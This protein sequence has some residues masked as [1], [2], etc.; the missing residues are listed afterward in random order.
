VKIVEKTNGS[1]TSTKQ[2]VWCPGDAQP[3]EERDA[4][5]NVTKRYYP[6]G[7]RIGST[8][9]Y[10]TRDHLGSIRELT[11]G[12]GAV[13]TRYDYDPYGRRTRLTGT[14]DA[15]FGFT[16]HY[17]HQPSGLHLALYRAY[18]ADLGR[19]ISRD[20]IGE[21]GGVNLYAYITNDPLNG[22]DPLGLDALSNFPFTFL[23][24]LDQYSQMRNPKQPPPMTDANGNKLNRDKYFHCMANCQ[25]AKDGGILDSL[26]LDAAREMHDMLKN[27][28]RKGDPNDK[29]SLE[30]MNANLK[31][32]K[33][34]LNPFSDCASRCASLL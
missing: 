20:P 4:S 5:N 24:F 19:W 12:S 22:I 31:G 14:L 32:L 29:D 34:G 13:Q 21:R 30:D 10:Y 15:D 23:H 18:N 8:N 11:N 17:Y 7:M 27:A 16:G 2:L 33:S 6:Q 25:S 3:C 9:Y 26:A 1:V 28:C